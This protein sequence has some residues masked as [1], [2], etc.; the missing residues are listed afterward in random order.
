MSADV[1]LSTWL[2][3]SRRRA[4]LDTLL[5]G[6]PVLLL[7]S[8]L[9]WRLAGLVPAAI[10]LL[11]G[12]GLL[13]TLIVRRAQRFDQ[14][15]LVRR[16]DARRV[17][18]EDSSGLLFADP[19]AL[20]PLQRLQRA[21]LDQ[22]LGQGMPQDL[23]PDWSRRAILALWTV[24]L[25]GIAALLLWPRGSDKPVVLAPAAEGIAAKPGIPRLVAQNLRIIPPAYT[26]VPLR[27]EAKLDARAPLGSRL[28]WT[29]RFDP[30]ASAPSLLPLGG[31][32]VA[33][34]R[35][36]DHWIASRP[37]DA[38]FL[39]RVDPASGRGPLPPL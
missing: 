39:Y 23:A 38:S 20:G 31:A 11:L 29:F 14:A 30:E 32:A 13:G 37:L 6:L 36:G 7:A 2:T 17:D 24:A 9:V 18:L 12:A 1:L 27:D 22:R 28:E 26:G 16:L 34:R 10:L 3:P 15:W 19:Q 33:L 4:R 5:L 25:L 21:R 8:A 35:D